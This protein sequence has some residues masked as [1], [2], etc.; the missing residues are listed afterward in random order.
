MHLSRCLDLT[1]AVS[2]AGGA[3][4]FAMHEYV[5][6]C[7]A[8]LVTSLTYTLCVG[9]ALICPLLVRYEEKQKREGHKVNH[10]FAKELITGIAAGE[11]RPVPFSS[12]VTLV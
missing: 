9:S 7:C 12:L 3:A 8:L 4:F 11:V 2:R 6:M 5:S 10:Q 1:F